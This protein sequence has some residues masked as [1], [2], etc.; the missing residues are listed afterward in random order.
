MASIKQNIRIASKEDLPL[1]LKWGK[2]MYEVEKQ[3]MPLLKYSGLEASNKYSKQIADPKF[4]FLIAELGEMPVGYLYAHIDEV[5]YLD[6]N[7]P[8]CEIEVIFL[9]AQAR[10]LGLSQKLIK[11]ASAWAKKKGAFEIKSGIFAQNIISRKAFKK[12]GFS[13][14]HTTYTKDI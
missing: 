13:L 2:K 3:Y 14:V 7:K 9:N 6:T 8:Q 1:L 5:E 11:S 12:S 10:G 4:L